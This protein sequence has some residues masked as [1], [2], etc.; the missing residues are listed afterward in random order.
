MQIEGSRHQIDQR[1]TSEAVRL[2]GAGVF[3]VRRNNAGPSKCAFRREPESTHRPCVRNVRHLARSCWL[4]LVIAH[5]RAAN[6]LGSMR[7]RLVT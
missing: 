3:A 4:Q 7:K 5:V 2:R 1:V 6:G